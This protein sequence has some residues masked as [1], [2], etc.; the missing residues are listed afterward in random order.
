MLLSSGIYIHSWQLWRKPLLL[1]GLF[2]ASSQMHNHFRI[3]ISPFEFSSHVPEAVGSIV[4]DPDH[5]CGD[6]KLSIA[7]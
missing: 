5:C 1:F 2:F 4:G 3:I 7:A 6:I